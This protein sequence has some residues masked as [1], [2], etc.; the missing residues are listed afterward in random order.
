MFPSNEEKGSLLTFLSTYYMPGTLLKMLCHL[1]EYPQRGDTMWVTQDHPTIKQIQTFNPG[2]SDL[3]G[4]HLPLYHTACRLNWQYSTLHC[5]DPSHPSVKPVWRVL[6]NDKISSCDSLV[7]EM[8]HLT[9]VPPICSMDITP[10]NFIFFIYYSRYW[11]GYSWGLRVLL[12]CLFLPI[13]IELLGKG[14]YCQPGR[15]KQQQ[16][17]NTEDLWKNSAIFEMPPF[18]RSQHFRIFTIGLKICNFRN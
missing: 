12:G 14:I 11:P 2:V 18:K 6:E 16:H 5:Y 8:H 7:Y 13:S 10:N 1:I 17:I 4:H 9:L 3:N 15:K